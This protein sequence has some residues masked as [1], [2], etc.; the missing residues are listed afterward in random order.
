MKECCGEVARALSQIADQRIA[1]L[2]DERNGALAALRALVKA[3]YGTGRPSSD[4][5]MEGACAAAM[6]LL[7]EKGER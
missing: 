2:V 7:K 6:A 3:T 1:E 4:R 5:E